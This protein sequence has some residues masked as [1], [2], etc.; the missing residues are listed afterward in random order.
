MMASEIEIVNRALIK[1][2][3]K[4]IL[5]LDD[6]KKSARTMKALYAPTR[7]Y[8]T[9]NHPWNFA[10]KRIEL[11]RNTADPVFG[12]QYSYKLPSDCLRVL[13]P[14]REI[15]VYGIEGR[16]MN[17]DY[18][19]AFIKYIARISD[20]NTFGESFQESLA[21]KLAAEGCISLTDNDA[22]HK[23][24]VQLYNL[25]IMEA[26]SVNAMEAGPKWIE[27]EEWLDSRRVGVAGTTGIHRGQPL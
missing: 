9:R 22:R 11:A 21:C 18:G 12:Y 17:T 10:I 14:N 23:A 26:R 27:S 13:I 25:S 7:D 8:V 4:T 15:W 24:M 16:N 1:L 5:S 20:P 19:D 2:G 3:E 6:D